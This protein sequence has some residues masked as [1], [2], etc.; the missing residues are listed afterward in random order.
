MENYDCMLQWDLRGHVRAD[1]LRPD[2]D[3]EDTRGAIWEPYGK[4]TAQ[5][6]EQLRVYGM[7]AYWA[8]EHHILHQ[9]TASYPISLN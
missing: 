1:G 5:A 6:S 3:G 8:S 9:M 2:R 7:G 4:S